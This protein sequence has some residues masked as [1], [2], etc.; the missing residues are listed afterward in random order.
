MAANR[1]D[2]KTDSG[3]R[4]KPVRSFHVETSARGLRKEAGVA[5]FVG[6]GT[7]R[8]K[9]NGMRSSR[10]NG[11]PSYKPSLFEELRKPLPAGCLPA[12]LP[13]K[14]IVCFAATVSGLLAA[15]QNTHLLSRNRCFRAAACGGTR[16]AGLRTRR[17]RP[18]RLK[19]R[20]TF[21]L[22]TAV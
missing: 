15:I 2:K 5:E 3:Q 7:A 4:F 13:S 14:S 22:I 12:A 18:A 9:G 17:L 11:K 21:P 6:C 8:D 10:L 16:R 1:P 19:S 20:K